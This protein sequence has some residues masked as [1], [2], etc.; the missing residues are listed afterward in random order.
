MTPFFVFDPQETW[1]EWEHHQVL[2]NI[3]VNIYE[4]LMYLSVNRMKVM[5][6]V[7]FLCFHIKGAIY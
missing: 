3:K 1:A 5:S 4:H 6:M 7:W 2:I